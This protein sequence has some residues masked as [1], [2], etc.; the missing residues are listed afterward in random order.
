MTE[1]LHTPT[2]AGNASEGRVF[3]LEGN[4]YL[5]VLLTVMG[6]LILFAVLGIMLQ[7]NKLLAVGISTLP[8]A[9]VLCWALCF[10][11]GKPAGYDRDILEH[12]RSRGNFTRNPTEQRRILR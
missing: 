12:W 2:N 1:L 6:S 9:T 7:L 8:I 10:K 11:K 3:G 5:P 4:L